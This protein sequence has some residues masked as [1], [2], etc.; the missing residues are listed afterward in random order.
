[1]V[2]P[3]ELGCLGTIVGLNVAG[4]FTDQIPMQVNMTC[5]AL[6]IIVLGA[7]RSVH[8]LIKEFKKIHVDKKASK[9]G[10]GI[11]TMSKDDVMQFPLY[12]GGTLCGL[13]FLIKF[14]GKEVINPLLLCY[15]GVGGSISIKSLLA[16]LGV[17][18]LDALE[19]KKL[20]HMKIGFMEIDQDVTLLDVLS[21]VIAY[22]FVAIYI[23]TKS[24]LFNNTLA[25]L[26][27]WN[28]IQLIFLGNFKNGFM[29]LTA[30]FF[31]DIFFVFGTD[32][33]LTVAKSIDAPIKIL[34]PT[35][36]SVDP[37]KFSLLG[38]GDIVIP[39]IFMA[40]CLR[41]DILRSLNVKAV[42]GLSEKG[43][44]DKVVTMLRK[45]TAN[46]PR[47]YFYGCVIGYVIAII[48]TV[49]VM[50][51]FEHGQPALL[52]LVPAVLGATL[53]NALRFGE[54]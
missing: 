2:D 21:L 11:E 39:G 28:A 5:Q 52:Y 33:M 7:F 35:D 6:A 51:V 37:P 27:S 9:E 54:L 12:A 1:M 47:P 31:Y 30:L 38:L 40:M 24:W 22:I 25:I 3:I 49:V 44:A 8:E 14:V 46:A 4:Y 42:N 29:M 16:G 34:F 15:M 53:I 18:Q 26:L 13:Y 32:V 45:A 10:E 36:W 48:I 19:E 41:Y 17:P 43:E 50:L 20:F 23:I